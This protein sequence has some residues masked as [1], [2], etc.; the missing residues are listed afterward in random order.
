[1]P[2]LQVLQVRER[3]MRGYRVKVRPLNVKVSTVLYLTAEQAKDL[4]D[5]DFYIVELEGGV[6]IP[7]AAHRVNK[8]CI[9]LTLLSKK[10]VVKRVKKELQKRLRENVDAVVYPLD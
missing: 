5:A 9:M 1:M 10:K 3:V 2:E 8:N 7:A 4:P 6:R